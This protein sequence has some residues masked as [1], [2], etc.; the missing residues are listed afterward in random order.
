MTIRDKK[1]T[2]WTALALVSFTMMAAYFF[3][4]VM[5]PLK[6]MLERTQGWS[7]D[8]Y[9]IFTSAY[10]WFNVFLLMLFFGGLLL[11]RKGIRFTGTLAAGLMVAGAVIKYAALS[12]ILPTEGEL[13]GLPRQVLF[14]SIGFGIYGIGSEVCGVVV[15]RTI[16][17]WFKGYE[18]ALAMGLQVAVAR[19]GTGLA[20]LTANPLAEKL[21][22][23]PQLLLFGVTMLLIGFV[24][25]MVYN[26]RFDRRLD[27]Q[28][29][30]IEITT[31]EDRFRLADVLVVVRNSGFWLIATLCVLFYS[32]VFPFMKY[33]PDLMVNKFG[34]NEDWAGGIVSLL[35]FGTILLTPV[36]GGIYDKKGR[37]ATIMII[38]AS[39][40]VVVHALFAAPW[41][42]NWIFAMAL[43]VL[44]GIAFSLVP[45]AMWPAVQRIIPEKQLGTAYALIFWVQNIGLMVVPLLIGSVLDKW[46]VRGVADG[47]KSYDYTLPMVIFTCFAILS[48]VI[49]FMLKREDRRKG[50]GLEKANITQ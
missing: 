3:Y 2:R 17:K 14:A 36:F 41:I 16:V 13:F 44:L 50:Y 22:G 32:C 48:V 8:D 1:S 47:A 10:S 37:G 35:P 38:G 42:T 4:D 33:A 40:L 26:F 11:D 9:G 30:E 45:S 46:C 49:G 18:L 19:I 21:Q 23:I 43:V 12:G 27:R 7:S 25:L 39:L 28:Q 5:A 31:E 15:S 34:V 29:G 24:V 20:M 6:G